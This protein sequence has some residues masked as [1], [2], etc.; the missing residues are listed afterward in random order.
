MYFDKATMDEI[1]KL[2]FNPGAAT[3]Y[4]STSEKGMSILI[5][6][7]RLGNEPADIRSWEQALLMTE[8]N[9]TLNNILGLTKK[10]PRP[11]ASNYLE[12]LRDVG[13]FCAL[14]WTL[15]G[16]QC[17]S[18]QNLFDLWTMLN[19]E[20][21]HAKA[22][23]F[24]PLMVRQITWAILEDSRQ[25]FFRTVTEKNSCATMCISQHPT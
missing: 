10:D 12:L 20:Q 3:A 8:C 4:F 24:G 23:K 2:K 15:F 1:T 9:H 5:V 22:D 14:V 25:F 21:V 7:P 16:D 19:S 18:F 11:P 6:C 17:D 13:S